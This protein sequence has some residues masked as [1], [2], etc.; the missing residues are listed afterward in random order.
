MLV[1]KRGFL[2]TFGHLARS[3]GSLWLD[4]TGA[5]VG[6][7]RPMTLRDVVCLKHQGQRVR[8]FELRDV[9]MEVGSH[10]DCDVTVHD[11]AV[12]PRAWLLQPRGGTVYAHDLAKASNL[13]NPRV[14]AIGASV[15]LG[16][17]YSI[18][19]LKAEPHT[20]TAV[21]TKLLNPYVPRLTSFSLI[22]GQGGEARAYHVDEAPVSI[23]AAADNTIMLSDRAVSRYHCRLEPSS[24]GVCIRDLDSTNG[25]WVDGVRVRRHVLRTGMVL[26]V[27]QTELRVAGRQAVGA[28]GGATVVTSTAMLAVMADVD[29]FARLPWPVV[30]RGETGVGKEHIARALHE[31]GVRNQGP[32]VALNAGGLP[33]E[34]VE[35][36]LFGHARGAFTGAIHAHRGAFEQADGGTLFLDEVAELPPDLQTRL[37]RILETWRVRRV[38][39]ETERPVDVRV[40]CATHRDLRDMVRD[41]CFR[42]DLYYRLHRLVV[43]V[44]ALRSRPDDVEPLASHFLQSMESEVGP[45]ELAADAL[46]RLRSYPWPGNVR[47]LRNVLEHAAADSDGFLI[48]LAAIDRALRRISEPFVQKPSIDALRDALEH[49]GGNVSAAARALGIPRSTLRD[50][51]KGS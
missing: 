33:R 15:P 22:R 29:R 46:A 11:Q 17:G 14:L 2:Q 25:T 5:V 8:A 12:P 44:P 51:L 34:L 18:T 24:G 50:R 47:E 13:R 40:I 43:E 21:R 42:A 19:R 31:R 41:G 32:F 38:G 6:R 28:G 37:L 10:P 39:S 26:R 16:G 48:G 20:A 35:S 7:Y 23:G 9:S 36:E 30:I 1:R 27:G 45:R 4:A 3:L 49:Y